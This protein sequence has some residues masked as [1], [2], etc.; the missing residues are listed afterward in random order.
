[1][2]IDYSDS[3]TYLLKTFP[4]YKE[5]KLFTSLF[6]EEDLKLPYIIWGTFGQWSVERLTQNGPDDISNKIVQLVNEQF[7]NPES[8]PEFINLLKVEI[9]E[10]FAQE[11]LSLDFMRKNLSSKARYWFERNLATTGIEGPDLT[12]AP[13]ARADMESIKKWNDSQKKDNN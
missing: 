7:D 1:M 6:D 13:E 4:E 5:S 10:N 12:I 9:F 2:R 3:V 11:K 8:D